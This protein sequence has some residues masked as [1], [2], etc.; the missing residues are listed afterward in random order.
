MSITTLNIVNTTDAYRIEALLEIAAA[1][2]EPLTAAEVARRRRIPAPFLGRLLAATA[3]AG[4]VATARGPRGGVRLARRP[5]LVTLVEVASPPPPGRAGGAAVAWLDAALA[6][7]RREV[8]ERTTLADL[9]AVDRRS[10][11]DPDW[12]I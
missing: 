11:T 8:L 10:S 2:P 12:N 7:A 9:V 5:E 6:A 1:F 4:I 3:H